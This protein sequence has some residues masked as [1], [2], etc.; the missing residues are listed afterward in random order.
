MPEFPATPVMPTELLEDYL[1]AAFAESGDRAG[2]EGLDVKL[3]VA[4][5]GEGGGEWIV[6]L[7]DGVM[8]VAAESRDDTS[9]TYVQSVDDWRGALWEGRGGAMGAQ[10]S[11][12]FRPGARE[13]AA[14]GAAMGAAPTP[15]ALEQLRSLDG[16]IRMVVTGGDGGDWSVGF[17]LGPGA[18][19]EDATTTVTLSAEDAEAMGRGE[20]NPME[21][22]MA[23]RIQVEGDVGF[24]MQLQ[25]AIMQLT[26]GAG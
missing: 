12:L 16:L 26:N 17:R 4:L 2:A 13:A 23:G 10:T 20:L 3:G 7:G 9:F 24:V 14:G 22:F 11:T 15:A 25:G 19:P 8:R 5:L 6:H 21:A 18:I 1:P